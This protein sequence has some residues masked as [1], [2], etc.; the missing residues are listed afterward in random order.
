MKKKKKKWGGGG[1]KGNGESAPLAITNGRKKNRTDYQ[2]KVSY[3]KLAST[4]KP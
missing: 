2:G 1:G 3:D 4:N